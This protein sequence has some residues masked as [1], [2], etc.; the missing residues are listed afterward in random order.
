MKDTM[1]KWKFV[2]VRFSQ[3]SIF[4]N[5]EHLLISNCDLRLIH[6]YIYMH[7]YTYLKKQ[8][9]K[10]SISVVLVSKHYGKLKH[11]MF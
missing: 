6:I 1:V 7:M 2:N 11:V 3:F 9:I 8:I 5:I 4:F 10:R